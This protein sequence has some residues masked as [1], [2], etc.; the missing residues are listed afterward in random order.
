MGTGTRH[1][2]PQIDFEVEFFLTMT[3]PQNQPHREQPQYQGQAWSPPPPGYYPQS[4]AGGPPPYPGAPQQYPGQPYAGQ[5]YPSQAPYPGQYPQLQQ[6]YGY[7]GAPGSW[8]QQDPTDVVGTRCWQHIL[9]GL[10]VVGLFIIGAIVVGLLSLVVNTM[11]VVILAIVL[12]GVAFVASWVSQAWWPISHNGQTP[13]M[14]WTKLRII[15]DQ[16]AAPS[17]GAL[18]IRWLLLMI[19]G[20]LI[21]LIV[22]A[23]TARHQRLGDLAAN[24]LVVRTE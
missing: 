24:T 16:G 21:G 13:A 10:V 3:N 15:T 1:S 8:V 2:S 19:E 9:D 20:G 22:M 17:M 23:C 7:P 11:A 14:Q 18:T 6:N 4:G 5:P 12:C